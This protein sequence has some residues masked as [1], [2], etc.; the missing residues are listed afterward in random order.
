MNI[1]RDPF[2]ALLITA[3]ILLSS[4]SFTLARWDEGMYTPDQIARLDLRKRGLKIKPQEIY[5]PAGGG[6]TDA[7]IRLSIGCTAEFVSPEGLIL[8]NH[9][10][11]F[12]ALVS[13]STP[14]NDL[15]EHGFR[16]DNRAGEI[17]AKGYSIFITRRIEDVTAKIRSGTE[18]LGG[19]EL[20]AAIKRN[21]DALSESAKQAAP[22]GSEIRIQSL[23]NGYFTIYIK[24]SRSR[25]SAWSMH[26]RETSVSSAAIRTISNG[27]D[28]QAIS[29]SFV[30]TRHLTVLPLIIRRITCR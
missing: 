1:K 2:A 3:S 15:V 6:L 30:L 9:H 27:R 13:A 16:T 4:V 12:D 23:N 21:T 25:T 18:N 20:A 7:V 17:P 24:F 26:R 8:T 11:A 29:L 28:I 19:E 5:N 10:C 14:E 22:A